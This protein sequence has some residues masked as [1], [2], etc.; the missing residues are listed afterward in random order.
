MRWRKAEATEEELTFPKSALC[1]SFSH[2]NDRLE[3]SA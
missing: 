3:V 1:K 2:N